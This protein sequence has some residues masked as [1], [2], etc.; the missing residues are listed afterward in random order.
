MLINIENLFL[1]KEIVEKIK[2][3][4]DDIIIKRQVKEVEIGDFIFVLFKWFSDSRFIS[5]FQENVSIFW[6]VLH[7]PRKTINNKDNY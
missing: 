2:S 6:L 4:I 1:N 5:F 3:Y 7:Y